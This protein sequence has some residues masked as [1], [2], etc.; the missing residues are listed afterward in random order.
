MEESLKGTSEEELKKNAV[1]SELQ[2]ELNKQLRAL[3]AHPLVPEEF[4][5]VF[6]ENL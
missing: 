5:I 4:K 1:I 3:L 6:Q 2:A